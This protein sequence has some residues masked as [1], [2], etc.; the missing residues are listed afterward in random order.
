MSDSLP[1]TRRRGAVAVISRGQQLLVIRRSLHVSAPGAYCFPGGGIEPGETEQQALIR[2]LREELDVEVAPV[3][4][5]WHCVTRWSVALAWW[6]AEL[7]QGT[8]RPNPAE[9][10]SCHWLTPDQMRELPGLLSSNSEFLDAVA[11]GEIRLG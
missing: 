1:E 8:P 9:V 2:E 4:R 7:V 5:L 6:R 3:E 10:A 11:R